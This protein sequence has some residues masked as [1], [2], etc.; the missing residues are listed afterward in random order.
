MKT[1]SLLWGV[2]FVVFV[3]GVISSVARPAGGGG[4]SINLQAT[5]ESGYKIVGGPYTGKSTGGIL[6]IGSKFGALDLRFYPGKNPL[7]MWLDQM[8]DPG[9]CP[10]QVPAP[11]SPFNIYNLSVFTYKEALL[12]GPCS[13][14]NSVSG[15]STSED[16]LNLLSMGDAETLYIQI[17]IRF[18]VTGFPN[19]FVMRPNKT[20]AI[21]SE[22]VGIVAVTARDLKANFPGVDHWEFMPMACP[23]SPVAIVDEANINQTYP[24]GR[25][26]NGSCSH[27][28]YVV[29]FLLVID[30]I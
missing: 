7:T 23:I 3:L 5:F 21:E 17:H 20:D 29:P 1:K 24:L 11:L 19:Y 18:E 27:G 12:D 6:Q 8:I 4:G 14:G 10:Q 30:R 15:Y 26:N 2:L 9:N 13:G 28:N 25:K 22:F 16:Y